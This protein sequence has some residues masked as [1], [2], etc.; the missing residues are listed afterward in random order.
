MGY[1]SY[2]RAVYESI[3]HL[4]MLLIWYQYAAFVNSLQYFTTLIP[5]RERERERDTDGI[6]TINSF[7]YLLLIM[8]LIFALRP[9]YVPTDM[10]VFNLHAE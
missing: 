6:I 7:Q 4:P 10:G 5:T 8:R 9:T 2:L 1:C 3:A